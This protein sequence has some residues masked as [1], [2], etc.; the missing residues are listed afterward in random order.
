MQHNAL[1]AGQAAGTEPAAQDATELNLELTALYRAQGIL[2]TAMGKPDAALNALR[3][4]LITAGLYDGRSEITAATNTNVPLP[5]EARA[6]G[7]PQWLIDSLQSQFVQLYQARNIELRGGITYSRDDGESGYSDLSALTSTLQLS[8]PLGSGRGTVI[9]DQIYFN[10]GSL[11]PEPYGSEFG[12]TYAT[13]SRDGKQQDFGVSVAFAYDEPQLSFDLGTAPLGFV[14]DDDLLGGLSY[15]FD[16]D[17]FSLTPELYRRPVTS[18]QLSFA[19]QCSAGECF[20]AVRKNGVA[21][22]F[23][24]DQ[25]ARDGFWGQI[26]AE[27]YRGHQVADNEAIKLMGGWYRRLINEKAIRHLRP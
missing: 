18:S 4:G 21:L 9:S 15:Q 19:G 27:W 24:L 13:G 23:S 3:S 17:E 14:E 26:A 22:N 12:Q 16:R 10:S 1:S 11:S 2:L 5:Q 25:G 8:F 6:R 7:T 20:G